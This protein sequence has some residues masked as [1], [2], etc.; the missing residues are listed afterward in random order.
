MK[1]VGN[2]KYVLEKKLEREKP[3]LIPMYD[4]KIRIHHKGIKKKSAMRKDWSY[5]VDDFFK[6]NGR[7][8]KDIISRTK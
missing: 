8:Q 4:K 3:N 7:I 2:S 1:S 6:E 5:Y